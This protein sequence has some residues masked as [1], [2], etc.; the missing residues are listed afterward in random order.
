L[1]TTLAHSLYIGLYIGYI[2][3]TSVAY[4][5]VSSVSDADEDGYADTYAYDHH[6]YDRE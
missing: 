1:A 5:D 4:E 6:G 2:G 3:P